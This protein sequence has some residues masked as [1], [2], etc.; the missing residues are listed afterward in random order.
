VKQSLITAEAS[1]RDGDYTEAL[2]QAEM[3]FRMALNLVEA[4]FVGKLDLDTSAFV[5]VNNFD[6]DKIDR[7]A[8]NAFK[9]MRKAFLI[10][11]IG[12][13]VPSFWRYDQI[14]FSVIN[15]STSISSG[16]TDV[17]FTGENV[18]PKNAAFVVAY[19]VNAVV[20]IENLVEDL[21]TPFGINW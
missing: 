17:I 11:T 4:A 8:F 20:Q 16:D 13:N 1:L 3:G 6:K 14:V 5:T 19:A 10:S 9:R 18:D 2:V 15:Y 12:L 21:D 7:R